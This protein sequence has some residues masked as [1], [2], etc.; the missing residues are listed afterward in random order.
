MIT[1]SSALLT[2]GRTD[3]FARLPNLYS[4]A[5]RITLRPS[6]GFV[7]K[8]RALQFARVL[9]PQCAPDCAAARNARSLTFPANGAIV[10]AFPVRECLGF[11]TTNGS[12]LAI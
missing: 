9:P 2:V 3:F 12:R 4:A 11:K 5:A 8:M 10:S 1:W 7:K 6:H